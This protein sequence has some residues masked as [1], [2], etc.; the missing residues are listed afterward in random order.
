MKRKPNDPMT[1]KPIQ[2]EV[3]SSPGCNRC[4]EVFELLQTITRDFGDGGIEWREVNVLEE[5]DYAVELGVLSMPAIAIDGELVFSSHP[6]A[7]NLRKVL[8][9]RLQEQ[10]LLSCGPVG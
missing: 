5:L 1:V 6:S 8:E 4:G 9:E 10:T 3:F 7:R 2:V